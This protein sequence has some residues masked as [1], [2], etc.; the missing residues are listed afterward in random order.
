MCSDYSDTHPKY[1]H[2]PNLRIEHTLLRPSPSLSHLNYYRK[3]T[4]IR[5]DEEIIAEHDKERGTRMKIDEPKTP[6]TGPIAPSDSVQA[7]FASQ[8]DVVD[9]IDNL[10]PQRK[11]SIEQVCTYVRQHLPNPDPDCPLL[12][13]SM[14]MGARTWPLLRR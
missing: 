3:E 8:E 6:Y 14:I 12:C 10:L 9:D 1:T 7:G 11:G 2:T 13:V 5:W 4:A